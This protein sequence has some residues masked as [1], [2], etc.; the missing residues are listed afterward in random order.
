MLTLSIKS[1]HHLILGTEYKRWGGY[2]KNKQNREYL[3][4]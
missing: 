3:A 1:D 4:T 2:D